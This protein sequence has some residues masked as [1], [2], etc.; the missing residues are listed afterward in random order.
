MKLPGREY[1]IEL[2]KATR[3]MLNFLYLAKYPVYSTKSLE[4]L[5]DALDRFYASNHILIEIRIQNNFNLPKLYFLCHYA[6]LI[7]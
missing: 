1:N 3:V 2:L 4:L 5:Q 7:K 6:N